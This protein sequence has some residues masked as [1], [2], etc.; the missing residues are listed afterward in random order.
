MARRKKPCEFCEDTW[1]SDS[2]DR[3]NGYSLWYEVYP[4]NN[5]IAVFAQ[6]KDEEG[7]LIED[8]VEIEMNF[9][10]VCGRRLNDVV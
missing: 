4:Y 5:H 9:C 6:A 3:R 10:P 2:I 7:E 8:C 1:F